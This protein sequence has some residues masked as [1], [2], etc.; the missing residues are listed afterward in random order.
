MNRL[1]ALLAGLLLAGCATGE[2]P[3]QQGAPPVGGSE[4]GRAAFAATPDTPVPFLAA[5]GQANFGRYL[6]APEPKAFALSASGVAVWRQG[7]T[8]DEARDAALEACGKAAPLG[9]SL[10]AENAVVVWR[11]PMTPDEQQAFARDQI[12]AARGPDGGVGQERADFN[13]VPTTD[14]AVAPLVGATPTVLPGGSVVTTAA[15]RRALL[16]AAPPRVIEVSSVTGT[17]IPTIPGAVWIDKA[18]IGRWQATDENHPLARQFREAM[19]RVAPDKSRPV[20]FTCYAVNCWQAYRAALRA[21]SLGYGDVAWYRG[22]TQSWVMAGLAVAQAPLD[23][24]IYD[25]AQEAGLLDQQDGE[26]QG[27]ATFDRR[28]RP[29]AVMR[30]RAMLVAA[31]NREPVFHQAIN[32]LHSMLTRA[33]VRREDIAWLSSAVRDPARLPSRPNLEAMFA[34]RALGPREGCFV[35]LTS[36]GDQRGIE[37]VADVDKYQLAPAELGQMLDRSCGK[38]PTIVVVSACHAGVYNDPAVL[39][40]NRILMTAAR[41]DRTSFGC[42]ADYEFSFYDACFLRSFGEAANWPDLARRV[43]ACVRD[44]ETEARFEPRS[45]PTASIG[46]EARIA[47][48]ISAPPARPARPRT[49]PSP[50]KAATTPGG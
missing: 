41:R 15:L 27:L 25:V 1:G 6:L 30:W 44:R 3:A 35:Y 28:T 46:A 8:T 13:I 14:L 38:A 24:A 34:P 16:G 33:G 26:L 36:H 31:H 12:A 23:A 17:R 29:F 5:T 18:G 22:G 40:P 42:S 20:V 32:R 48:M 19:A 21:L 9:C 7:A 2:S 11:G 4:T 45:L 47:S 39:R 37:V 50:A 10:F 43:N 49:A